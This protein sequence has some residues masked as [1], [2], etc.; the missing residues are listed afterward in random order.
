M[1]EGRG[2]RAESV[3]VSER[4]CRM[5]RGVFEDGGRSHQPKSSGGREAGKDKETE[6]PQES[7]EGM[8]P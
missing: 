2:Q 3:S 7:V 6:T 8:Q 5:R 4:G 1:K